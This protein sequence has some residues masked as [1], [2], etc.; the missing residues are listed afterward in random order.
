MVEKKSWKRNS[1]IYLEL[2]SVLKE[3]SRNFIYIF[4]YKKGG[5]KD[6]KS[7]ANVQKVMKF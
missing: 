4:F 1:E 5:L 7:F 6:L 3:A 2:L